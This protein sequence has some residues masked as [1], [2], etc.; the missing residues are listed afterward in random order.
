M[1]LI[2]VAI[3][4][5]TRL[6]DSGLSMTRW[7]PV[8]GSLPPLTEAAWQ[9]AFED[10]KQYPEFYKK[11]PD[12]SLKEFKSI[13][14]WEYIHR[15]WARLIGLVFLFPFIYF[16]RKGKIS[17]ALMK[18]LGGVAVLGLAQAVMG[19]YM[20]YSGMIDEPWVSPYRLTAHLFL[21]MGIFS[22]LYYLILK[23]SAKRPENNAGK[24]IRLLLKVMA[25]LVLIQIA[26]GGLVAG[27]DAARF[28]NTWPDMDGQLIPSRLFEGGFQSSIVLENSITPQ[29]IINV[30]F[31]HRTMAI[32]ISLL[33][34][35]LFIRSRRIYDETIQRACNWVLLAVLLQAS[36]G[37]LTIIN[38]SALQIA[39][40]LGALHQI[41][42][43]LL[44]GTLIYL[45]FMS[46][47]KNIKES[48]QGSL[49]K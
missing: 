20:V 49:L 7:E 44:V 15:A 29:F 19:W 40:R 48:T 8:K 17:P 4:G 47:P 24:P 27:S 28:Y 5:I 3:G 33:S 26:Y 12:F 1:V 39:V 46:N 31:I 38:S 41:A 35:A 45:G 22:W 9:E 23:T 34:I 16:W 14:W 18:N 21:A 42:A 2:Q 25:V 10:Y 11:N 32:I 37:V 13:F 6:T 43:F 30:Q 36:L